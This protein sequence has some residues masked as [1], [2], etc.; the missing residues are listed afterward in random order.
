[1]T[2]LAAGASAPGL[3]GL[4]GCEVKKGKRGPRVQ[5]LR[6]DLRL[7]PLLLGQLYFGLGDGSR[8][9]RLAILVGIADV[10]NLKVDDR[11]AEQLEGLGLQALVNGEPTSPRCAATCVMLILPIS[12]VKRSIMKDSRFA[13]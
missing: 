9:H 13:R 4:R 11:N 7:A 5:S 8:I 2:Q 6:V 1:M 3:G 10:V 12:R